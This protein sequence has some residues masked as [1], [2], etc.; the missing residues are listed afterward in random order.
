MRGEQ[1]ME[2]RWEE[3]E[4]CRENFAEKVRFRGNVEDMTCAV[5]DAG[6][7]ECV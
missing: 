1:V 5:E 2:G 6:D 3:S 4:K 7:A